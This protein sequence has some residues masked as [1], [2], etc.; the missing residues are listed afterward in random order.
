MPSDKL[1]GVT[2]GEP[3]KQTITIATAQVEDI[4]QLQATAE[5]SWWSTYGEYVA[6]SFIEDFLARAYSTESLL[7]QVADPRSCFLVAKSSDALIGFGQ[8]GPAMPRRDNAPVAPADLYRLY[9]LPAWQGQRI[10]STLLAELE[11]WLRQRA[12]P[13]YGAYVHERNEPAKSFYARRGFVH[14]PECDVQDEWYLVK[15]LDR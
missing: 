2:K 3:H 12:Y 8:V 4:P 9:L 11:A 7:A 15:R 13:Y 6:A 10:G 14:K 5:E 1:P